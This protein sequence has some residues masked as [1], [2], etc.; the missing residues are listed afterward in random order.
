MILCRLCAMECTTLTSSVAL[1]FF[2][3]F[4]VS[5]CLMII[6]LIW[7]FC[8][9]G[10]ILPISIPM[11]CLSLSSSI[12]SFYL[13]L[14]LLILGCFLL[15]VPCHY[16]SS[17]NMIFSRLISLFLSATSIYHPQLIAFSPTYQFSPHFSTNS[18]PF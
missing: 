9:V 15:S 18:S 4:L 6:S 2:L 16:L 7:I 5:M 1:L 13:L 12:L 11:L 8:M 3:L 10:S 17:G 14:C